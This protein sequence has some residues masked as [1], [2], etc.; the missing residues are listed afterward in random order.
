MHSVTV[1]KIS[2]DSFLKENF[3]G[4]AK[5]INNNKAFYPKQAGVG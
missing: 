4:T 1:K 5:N 2:H 3:H